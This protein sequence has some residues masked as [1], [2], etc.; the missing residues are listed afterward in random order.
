MSDSAREI[1]NLVYTYAERLDAGDLDGV[2]ALF[3]HGR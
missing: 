3:A 1:E 2:A